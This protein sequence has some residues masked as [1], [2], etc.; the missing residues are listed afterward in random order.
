MCGR[1]GRPS[2]DPS[3][4]PRSG[5]IGRDAAQFSAAVFWGV[6]G[7]SVT[8]VACPEAVAATFLLPSLVGGV[9]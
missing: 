2:L 7:E 4:G 3:L 6:G 5:G 8:G 1:L 9:L